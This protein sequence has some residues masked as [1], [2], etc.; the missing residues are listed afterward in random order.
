MCKDLFLANCLTPLQTALY[1]GQEGGRE[2][3]RTAG[4]AGILGRA[5]LICALHLDSNQ[6]KND[7]RVTKWEHLNMDQELGVIQGSLLI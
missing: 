3:E 7:T 1:W 4:I 6:S 5:K 2:W